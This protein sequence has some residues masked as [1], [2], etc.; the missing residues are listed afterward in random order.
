LN[1]KYWIM[2]LFLICSVNFIFG[3]IKP[4]LKEK[5]NKFVSEGFGFTYIEN[6]KENFN[7]FILNHGQPLGIIEETIINKHDGINDKIITLKYEK[8]ILKYYVWA[9]R[10]TGNYPVSMLLSI[11]SKDK[12]NYLYNIKHGMTKKELENIIG[13]TKIQNNSIWIYGNTGNI[14]IIY[15][16]NN[17]IEY[18]IWHYSLE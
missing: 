7:V 3:Q 14:A 18:I 4:G 12:I 1:K 13:I 5:R 15:L 2:I 11:T 10:E 8:Y 6:E 17:K 16:K 9:E